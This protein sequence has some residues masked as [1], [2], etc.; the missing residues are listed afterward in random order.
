MF[1]M[2]SFGNNTRTYI[3]KSEKKNFF[4]IDCLS[5]FIILNCPY[6]FKIDNLTPIHHLT[7]WQRTDE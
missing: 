5:L 2:I 6:S 4:Q 7:L 1:Y 3:Y